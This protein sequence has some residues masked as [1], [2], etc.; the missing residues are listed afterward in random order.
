MLFKPL[1]DVMAAAVGVMKEAEA[2]AAEV[3]EE[4]AELGGNDS[5]IEESSPSSSASS[6]L[7]RGAL[8]SFCRGSA[9]SS[10]L[11]LDMKRCVTNAIS[12]KAAI[13][14]R[15]SSGSIDILV[16]LRARD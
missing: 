8:I 16:D 13:A 7:P 11:D 14:A 1:N 15:S 4:E 9:P 5:A 6:S 10:S 3:E 12:A 2:E